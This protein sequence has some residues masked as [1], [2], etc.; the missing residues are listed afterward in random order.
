M[1]SKKLS[2]EKLLQELEANKRRT[3]ALKYL[4]AQGQTIKTELTSQDPF[5]S[6]ASDNTLYLL[7]KE[8]KESIV[9]QSI[10]TEK[11]VKTAILKQQ[12]ELRDKVEKNDNKILPL[13]PAWQEVLDTSTGK[14]YYWNTVTNETSWSRPQG[15]EPKTTTVASSSVLNLPEGWTEKIHPATNQK[16]YVH[17]SGK[18]SNEFPTSSSLIDSKSKFTSSIPTRTDIPSDILEARTAAANKK[19]KWDVDPLDPTGVSISL[20]E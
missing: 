16:Y 12:S 20:N 9:K 17:K 1:S 15:V 18:V 2:E 3:Q 13:P 10:T 7:S 6:K 19:R 11:D 8:S 5:R 4:E 14:S